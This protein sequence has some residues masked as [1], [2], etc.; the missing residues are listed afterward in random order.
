MPKNTRMI[1]KVGPRIKA[2]KWVFRLVKLFP[3][4]KYVSC[5]SYLSQPIFWSDY[6]ILNYLFICLVSDDVS[7]RFRDSKAGL[8]SFWASIQSTTLISVHTFDLTL[9]GN[10]VWMSP[11]GT[12]QKPSIAY[13]S[14]ALEV[15]IT[16]HYSGELN[17]T[18]CSKSAILQYAQGLRDWKS[19]LRF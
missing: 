17:N 6:A 16:F 19:S 14:W 12:I 1:L 13:Q 4:K 3:N 15:I 5:K 9:V 8:K 11:N 7:Y 10:I 18:Y 2:D